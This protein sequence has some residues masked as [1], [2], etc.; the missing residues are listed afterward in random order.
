[1]KLMAGVLGLIPPLSPRR[2]HVKGHG[3]LKQS[4]VDVQHHLN[5]YHYVCKTDVKSFCESIDQYLLIDMIND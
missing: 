2:T 5:R 1:M 4:I 3:S